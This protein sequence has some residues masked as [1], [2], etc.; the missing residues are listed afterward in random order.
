MSNH[1][2]EAFRARY[3]VEICRHYNAWLHGG[4]VFVYGLMVLVALVL[5]VDDLEATDWLMI[6]LG[7][8][9]FNFGEY[10]VHRHFGHHKYRIGALFYKRHTGDHH[11]FFV[12]SK[13]T[14]EGPRD[15]RVIFF[16][17][18]LIVLYSLGVVLPAYFVVGQLVDANAGALFAATLLAGYLSYEFFHACQHLPREHGLAKLP[19]IRETAQLHRL[20]H[21][22][23]LMQRCNF[24]LVFPL[25]DWL[26]GTL[27]W[28]PIPTGQQPSSPNKQRVADAGSP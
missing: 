22:R 14:Y 23:D 16:P 27:Y 10:T 26:H 12:E 17:A 3:R 28:E 20:H 2:T 6:P 25:M 21:R 8:I 1:D 4:F 18:W 11:S 9:V 15:W 7:L 13:M 24:N 5:R 19:W